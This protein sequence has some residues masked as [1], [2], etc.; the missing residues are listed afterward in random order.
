MVETLS[1]AGHRVAALDLRPN[2]HSPAGVETIVGDVCDGGLL[3]QVLP[4]VDMVC[5]QAAKVGLGVSAQDLPD[6]VRHNDLGTAEVLAAMDRCR[7]GRMVLASSMVVYGE[8]RYECEQHGRVAAPPRRIADLEAGQFDPRCATCDAPLTPGLIDEDSILDPRNAYA[9]TKL[10]QEHLVSSW[11]RQVNGSAI[12]LR[13][14]NVYGPRMP[15]DTP[16]AGV[17]SIFRSMIAA[18]KAPAVFEDGA[19]R[20]DFVHV[21]DVAAANLAAVN[22]LEPSSASPGTSRAYN[23]CSGQVRT[24]H[25]LASALS[26]ELGGQTPRVTGQFR[27][28]DV[29]HIT[30]SPQRIRE[31][32]GWTSRIGFADG[33]AE[34]SRIS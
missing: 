20:R 34:L 31:E 25:D 24:V 7:V 15:R 10:A 4:G 9:A 32:L 33:V 13:Y 12:A 18:G 16:Y 26:E 8:G 19:Q 30:A 21:R 14:H 11:T 23:V 3:D 28:G 27:L 29:R 6:Y 5:H 1:A 17:A 22:A 2:P